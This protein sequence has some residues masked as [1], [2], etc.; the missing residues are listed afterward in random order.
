MHFPIHAFSYPCIFLSMQRWNHNREKPHRNTGNSVPYSLPTPTVKAELCPNLF[1]DPR[2]WSCW[3]IK[4]RCSLLVD[5]HKAELTW[6]ISYNTC[7]FE[8]KCSL[9]MQTLMKH[10]LLYSDWSSEGS[11]SIELY[12]PLCCRLRMWLRKN[13]A[14]GTSTTIP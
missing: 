8:A 2:C 1:S 9:K 10:K 5:L 7:K 12:K 6:F 11:S 3:E 4:P 14:N 13:D